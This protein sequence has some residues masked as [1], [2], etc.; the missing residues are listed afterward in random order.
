MDLSAGLEV[1]IFLDRP[2]IDRR[3]GKLVGTRCPE[4]CTVSWPSRALCPGCGSPAV[5]QTRFPTTGKLLTF[6]HV[7][8]PRGDLKTPYLLGQVRIYGGPVVFGHLRGSLPNDPLP[9]RVVVVNPDE[10]SFPPF[11]F[12]LDEQP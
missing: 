12:E 5:E 3:T 7:W 11:W 10:G 2:R 6:T 9:V 1:A 4:C 8:I